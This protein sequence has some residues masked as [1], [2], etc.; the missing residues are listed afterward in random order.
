MLSLFTLKY[1][2]WKE[3]FYIVWT[4][5]VYIPSW[6]FLL[7]HFPILFFVIVYRILT[8]KPFEY[9]LTD[10]QAKVECT[11]LL[12]KVKLKKTESFFFCSTRILIVFSDCRI[13]MKQVR[14]IIN[15]CLRKRCL[16]LPLADLSNFNTL[17]KLGVKQCKS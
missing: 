4:L 12:S 14:E 2:L 10:V 15:T 6:N 8:D 7:Y 16:R 17:L 9:Y 1:C 13:P 11:T 5:T 3:S